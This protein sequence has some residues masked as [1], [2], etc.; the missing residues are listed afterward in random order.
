MKILLCHT[1]YMQRGGEDICFEEERELLREAGHTVVEYVRRNDALA[2]LSPL[3]AAAATTW[4]RRAASEVR[5]LVERE[6]PDVLHATNTFPLLSPAILRA[7][8]RQGTAVVQAL[9]NFRNVCAGAYLMRDGEPC[10]ECLGRALPLPA[11]RHR[12]YRRSL[13]ASAAVA[14]MQVLHRRMGTWRRYVDAFFAPSDFAR[15]KLVEGGFPADRVHVKYNSVDPDPGMGSGGDQ[16][17]FV[18]RLSPE[19]GIATLLEAW[20]NDASLPRLV[21]VGDGPLAG[22]VAD[23]AAKD[24]RIVFLGRQ[25]L[26]G[27]HRALHES[28]AII[29]PSVWYETFGR[30]IVEGFASGAIV[31][32]SRMGAMQELV[33]EGRTGFSFQPGDSAALG[34]AVHRV[35][36]L[37]DGVVEGIRLA[38]RAEFERQYRPEQNYRRLLEIYLTAIRRRWGGMKNDAERFAAVP[39]PHSLGDLRKPFEP[40]RLERAWEGAP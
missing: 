21:V 30:T 4:N 3:R 24:T 9:H 32:A 38:A 28:R 2:E 5:R 14:A 12:C 7:A 33:D 11:I 29:V 37:S 10:E 8:R 39:S 26:T 17:A 16:A 25:P 20:R 18:G 23:A 19:K 34:S 15:R 27:V 22:A 31:V 40:R 6:N 13:A 35:W 36:G 1:Y